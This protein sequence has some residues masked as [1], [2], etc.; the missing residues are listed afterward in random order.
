MNE[1]IKAIIE[2]RSSRQ[3]K[4]DMP[5]KEI[6]DEIINAGLYAANG[7]GHQSPII[8]AIT[9]KEARDRL[10]KVNAEIANWNFD[11]FYGAPVVLVVLAEKGYFTSVYDG[12]AVMQNLILAAHSL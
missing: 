8:V 1:V 9:N 4:P 2:R 3:F 12:S 7:M 10:A 11:P 5:P 6:I